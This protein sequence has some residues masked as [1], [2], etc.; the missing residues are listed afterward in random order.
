VCARY[1]SRYSSWFL[2]TMPAKFCHFEDTK[3]VY[4]LPVAKKV[5]YQ[6]L[7]SKR[8]LYQHWYKDHQNTQS[9][10]KLSQILNE[11]SMLSSNVYNVTSS[12]SKQQNFPPISLY[13][14]SLGISDWPYYTSCIYMRSYWVT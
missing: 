7:L 3:L 2:I 9:L 1:F 12:K 4:L 8:F 10:S 13:A 6:K 5:T 14:G 11:R